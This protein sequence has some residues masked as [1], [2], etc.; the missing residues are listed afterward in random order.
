MDLMKKCIQ[1]QKVMNEFIPVDHINRV[2]SK[3]NPIRIYGMKSREAS[4]CAEVIPG[5]S[6]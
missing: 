3:R 5:L 1:I 6:G 2:I 4:Q